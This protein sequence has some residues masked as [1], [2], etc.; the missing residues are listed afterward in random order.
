MRLVEVDMPD[1]AE[2][3][4]LVTHCRRCPRNAE[5]RFFGFLV[6]Y[7]NAA[8]EW[9]A[10]GVVG[11]SIFHPSQRSD[12]MLDAYLGLRKPD[13]IAVW[14]GSNSAESDDL[15]VERYGARYRALLD[16]LRAAAP[17]AACLVIG[18]PDLD[19][20][21]SGC[22]LSPAESRASRKAR[23]RAKDRALLR[24]NLPA[25][26]C[27]PDALVKSGRNGQPIYPVASVR[28]AEQWDAYKEACACRT[29]P[30]VPELDRVSREA[31]H[32]AGCAYFSTWEFMGGES[33]MQRFACQEPRLGAYDLV[34]LTHE[35]YQ[36]IARSIHSAVQQLG[37]GTPAVIAGSDA[38]GGE[39]RS[40]TGPETGK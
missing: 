35:G 30:L 15:D 21:P 25:R 13:L 7:E 33:S 31:A 37:A 14:F 5:L 27:D 39:A 28:T 8:V 6:R 23:K 10:L 4:E 24:L 3:L 11:T 1:D 38:A 29:V 32:A 40:E 17:D 16:R 36:A 20:R 2:T 19:A 9:D 18:L 34:H 26:A 22:F 12:A